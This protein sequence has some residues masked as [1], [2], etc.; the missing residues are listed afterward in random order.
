[1]PFNVVRILSDKQI[2]ISA[3]K[4]QNAT[5]GTKYNVYEIGEKII[6]PETKNSLGT[7][8]YIKATVEVVTTYDN[9]SIAEYIT[10]STKTITQGIMSAFSESNKTVT[11]KTIHVLPVDE[12]AI[13][14]QN[15][16]NKLIQ[17]GDPIKRV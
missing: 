17:I 3:G 7:L 13:K 2:V 12:E 6:D 5:V 11:E 16:K 15:I 10:R 1:M 9:F 8:D 4:K 14:P